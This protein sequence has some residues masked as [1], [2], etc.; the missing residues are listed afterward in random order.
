VNGLLVGECAQ[1]GA[2]MIAPKWAEH[3]SDHCVRNVWSCEAC[4]YQFEDLVYL[5]VQATESFGT[6]LGIKHW[7]RHL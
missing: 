5:S 6:G 2:E 4:G 3:V 7:P 1:C